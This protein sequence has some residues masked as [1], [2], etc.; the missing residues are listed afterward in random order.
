MLLP[1]T[2]GRIRRQPQLLDQFSELETPAAVE[3]EE[4]RCCAK[5]GG[6]GTVSFWERAFR[7]RTSI[8]HRLI[9]ASTLFAE[10]LTSREN[11]SNGCV[12]FM[13][14]MV[15]TV[16]AVKLLESSCHHGHPSSQTERILLCGG[17]MELPNDDLYDLHVTSCFV[18]FSDSA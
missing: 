15:Y 6:N 13:Q 7:K 18:S 4:S 11:R 3:E 5:N 12:M 2:V 8:R 14:S 17:G 10:E 9:L 1:S 16:A